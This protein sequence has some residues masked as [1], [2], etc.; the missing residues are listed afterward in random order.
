MVANMA[1]ICPTIRLRPTVDQPP[2]LENWVKTTEADCLGPSAQSIMIIISHPTM[3]TPST[4][5]IIYGNTSAHQTLAMKSNNTI[6]KTK[7]VPCQ[8]VGE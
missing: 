5:V 8:L 7:S 3:W 2:A 6:A 4:P 1:V